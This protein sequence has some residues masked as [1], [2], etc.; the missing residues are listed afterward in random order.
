MNL[1]TPRLGTVAELLLCELEAIVAD[2]VFNRSPAQ[3]RM[4]K[5]LV[6]A[7]AAGEGASLKSYTLAV[8]GLG[9]SEDFDAQ[10]NTYSRVLTAR[11]RRSLEAYYRGPGAEREWRLEIPQGSYEV[12][13]RPNREGPVPPPAAPGMLPTPKQRR[14]LVWSAAAVVAALVLAGLVWFYLDSRAAA[15]RWQKLNFP[16]VA[17]Q[18]TP[19]ATTAEARRMATVAAEF[20]DAVS[21]YDSVRVADHTEATTEYILTLSHADG[22]GKAIQVELVNR[23]RNRRLYSGTI[24]LS[25]DGEPTPAERLA[26]ERIVFSLFGYAS[27]VTSLE[28]RNSNSADTPFDCWLRFSNS[29]VTDGSAQDPE[30]LECAEDWYAHSPRHPLAGAIYGWTLAS[31]TLGDPPG[32][33]RDEQLNEALRIVEQARARDPG[34]R[35]AALS[36]ARIYGLMGNVESLRRVAREISATGD[37][38]PDVYSTVGLLLVFQNDLTGEAEIDRAIAFHPSPP[39]R[40]FI[41]KYIAAMMREDTAGA[42]AALQ[43]IMTGDSATNWRIYLQAA[44][45][46]RIGRT[47]E[48]RRVWSAGTASRPLMRLFPRYYLSNAPAAPAVKQRL[49]QWLGPVIDR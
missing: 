15:A 37:L 36:L 43:R 46:A 44:Y 2:P 32:S 34:S 16:L 7:S 22:G 23:Q 30:L 14:R 48:A 18:V 12:Q 4:L 49:G 1:D 39:P 21:Q 31:S 9:R 5:Y 26:L 20:A 41:G 24:A 29:V 42:G 6:E 10:T 28:T 45:L 47:E 3:V 11:L 19:S 25:G 33:R 8:E 17:I 27:A 38:N 35:L 13:L 40:Y